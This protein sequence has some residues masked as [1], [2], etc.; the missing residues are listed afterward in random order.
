MTEGKN[1]INEKIRLKRKETYLEEGN[2]CMCKKS[3]EREK[4]GAGIKWER[5]KKLSEKWKIKQNESVR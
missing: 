3:D 5:E 2:V 4:K 1:K